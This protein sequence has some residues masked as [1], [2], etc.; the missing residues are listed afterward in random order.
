MFGLM[1]LALYVALVGFSPQRT[2]T[3][4]LELLLQPLRRTIGHSRPVVLV[5]A[6]FPVGVVMLGLP[7]L[8]FALLGGFLCRKFRIA[9]R[10]DRARC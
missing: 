7:Q 4:Y 9:E 8:T 3:P 1:A 10:S 2:V 6:L 5:A